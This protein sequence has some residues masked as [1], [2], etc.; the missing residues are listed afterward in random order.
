MA[1]VESKKSQILLLKSAIAPL[2]DLLM[3]LN[4]ILIQLVSFSCVLLLL[5]ASRLPRGWVIVSAIILLVLAG[6]YYFAPAW[7]GFISGGLWGLLILLPIVGFAQVNRLV[8][9][10]KYSQARGLAMGLRWLHP[11]DGLF[12]YPQL[13]RGMELGHQGRL[14]E[15]ARI[16]DR[17]GSAKTLMGRTAIAL[18]YRAGARWDELLIWVE[19]HFQQKILSESTLAVYYLRALG[20][21]GSLEQLIQEL[22]RFEQRSPRRTDP[23]TLNLVRMFALAF[24]GQPEQVQQVFDDAL[25]T[26]PPNIREFWL[27]TAEWAAGN[28]SEARKRLLALGDRSDAVLRN[29]IAWRLSHPPADPERALSQLSKQILSRLATDIQQES[30]YGSTAFLKNKAYATY[31]LIAANV[32]VFA[33]EIWQGGSEDLETLYQL[34]A[35][36]PAV[37]FAGEWWRL[38][39]A[40]FLHYGV[41]HLLMNMVGLYFLGTIA[42]A[43]LGSK[44]FLL[45]YFFSGV[46]S[47]LVVSLI[48]I[49]LGS[50]NQIVVGASGAIMGL[51]GAIGAILLQG[52]YREKARVAAKR[53][54][55]V[56]FIIG[57]QIVFDLATPQVSFVGHISG[58]VL[59]FLV[60]SLLAIASPETKSSVEPL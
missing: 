1:K 10:E 13:L 50:S 18:L 58:L 32:A 12:E 2:L 17:Y 59:G 23:V 28:E 35:L 30:R 33:V 7:A 8:S 22:E 34:G 45:A 11:A 20:E 46:G 29:A 44:K 15:A 36:V 49:R 16:F 9:Q 14:E 52:W 55:T 53:L 6:A 56:L 57:L 31:A 39:S 51:L 21:T 25:A 3:D 40:T 4:V 26:H 42:E 47:M 24:G 27:A 43:S 19:H 48:A 41:A 5:R 38:L 54:R 37:V 60:G